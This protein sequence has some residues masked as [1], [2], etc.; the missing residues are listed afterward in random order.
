MDIPNQMSSS[1][2]AF[3]IKP[4]PTKAHTTLENRPDFNWLGRINY[5]FFCVYSFIQSW[6]TRCWPGGAPGYLFNMCG[7]QP[8]STG[9]SVCHHHIQVTFF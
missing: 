4:L 8:S 5:I 7:E 1:W 6:D 2:K 9:L 3:P